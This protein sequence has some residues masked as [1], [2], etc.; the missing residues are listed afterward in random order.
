VRVSDCAP[1]VLSSK[2]A[3]DARA[4]ISGKLFGFYFFFCGLNS[5]GTKKVSLGSD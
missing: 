3:A 4:A 5:Q 1:A 2:S